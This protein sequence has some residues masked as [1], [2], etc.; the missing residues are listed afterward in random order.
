MRKKLPYVDIDIFRIF[1]LIKLLNILKKM[2][3]KDILEKY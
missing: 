3:I 2:E 1:A